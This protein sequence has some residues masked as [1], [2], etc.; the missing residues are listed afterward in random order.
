MKRMGHPR[1]S[2]RGGFSLIE[3][4][5]A[6]MVIAIGLLGMMALV[7]GALSIQAETH[8]MVDAC[9]IS[10]RILNSM[11]MGETSLDDR[12]AVK[13]EFDADGRAAAGSAA[14]L[15]VSIRKLPTLLQMP[16]NTIR[17]A[18]Q[19]NAARTGEEIYTLQA[20]VPDRS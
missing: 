14:V 10:E 12:A 8:S 3:V 19:V 7:P 20:I 4:T 5:L 18:I 11:L 16:P 9:L 1:T 2:G 15:Q 13:L 6:L 17:V